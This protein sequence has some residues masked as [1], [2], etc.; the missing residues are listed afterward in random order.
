MICQTPTLTANRTA[1]IPRAT[2]N[3]MPVGMGQ[4]VFA[5]SPTRLTTILGSFVAVTLYSPSR[6]I[7]ALGHV[8]LP[9][10]R[11]NNDHPAKFADTAIPH[12]L[13]I[14]RREGVGLTELTAKIAGG[15]CM[16]GN[17]QFE[18]IGNANV[19]AVLR[20]MELAGLAVAGSDA[21][22]TCGR[23]VSFDLATG[24]V[25]V[26]VVGQTARII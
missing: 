22:G 2:S 26:A 1:V 24:Q 23:R 11:G 7:G 18:Q 9:Q 15:A 5:G 17:G 14:L 12:M 6:R 16:F 3:D 19:E 21:G 20:A 10:S 25:S 4:A 8:V 13:A